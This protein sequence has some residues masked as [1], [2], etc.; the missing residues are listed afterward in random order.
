MRDAHAQVMNGRGLGL[1]I[2]LSSVVSL[3]TLARIVVG[4]SVVGLVAWLVSR[5]R[6][7]N[8]D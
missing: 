7:S 6:R 3:V 1:A 2:D 4:L 8:H 5:R